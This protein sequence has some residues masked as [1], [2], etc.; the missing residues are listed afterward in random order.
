MTP[1]ENLLFNSYS[2]TIFVGRRVSRSRS[3]P[4]K[5]SQEVFLQLF[6]RVNHQC[7]GLKSVHR[8]RREVLHLVA[9]E[10]AACEEIEEA[11]CNLTSF[12]FSDAPQWLSCIVGNVVTT[13]WKAG[14]CKTLQIWNTVRPDSDSLKTNDQNWYRRT[15]SIAFLIPPEPHKAVHRNSESG[16]PCGPTD[17]ESA[18]IIQWQISCN[19]FVLKGKVKIKCLS[20]LL[21]NQNCWN[22][23]NCFKSHLSLVWMRDLSFFP[24]CICPLTKKAGP[25]PA[26]LLKLEPPL[27][28]TFVAWAPVCSTLHVVTHSKCY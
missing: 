15:R 22:S 10:E 25:N 17:R 26:P 7:H 24:G 28:A 23:K 14:P 3:S 19:D 21:P 4:W 13:S 11:A 20:S 5:Y 27:D 9:K 16:P 12:A 2:S 1:S 18:S 6:W 8:S